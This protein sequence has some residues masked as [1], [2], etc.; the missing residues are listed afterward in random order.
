MNKRTP[1][2]DPNT[3]KSRLLAALDQTR[4]LVCNSE[5]LLAC[6][7]RRRSY[8]LLM[9]K[10]STC[11]VRPWVSA[12]MMTQ[13]FELWQPWRQRVVV[14][15]VVSDRLEDFANHIEKIAKIFAD[16]MLSPLI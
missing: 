16:D 3:E 15:E 12:S 13:R 1:W 10:R 9:A 4:R 7:K 14:F 2:Y 8:L 5:E 6:A 11:V